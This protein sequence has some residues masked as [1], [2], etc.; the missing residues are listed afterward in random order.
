VQ[1]NQ[2]TDESEDAYSR[3][4]ILEVPH[5]LVNF[6]RLANAIGSAREPADIGDPSLVST[7]P[8]TSRKASTPPCCHLRSG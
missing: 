6:K 3:L 1:G 8:Q 5:Q 7:A 4:I 2:E